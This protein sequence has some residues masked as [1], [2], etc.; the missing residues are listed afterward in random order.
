MTYRLKIN[1]AIEAANKIIK[2]IVG[3]MVKTHKDWHKKLPFALL[4]YRTSVQTLTG[5]MPYSLFY[6]MR[7]SIKVE[8]LSLQVLMETKLE[9][10]K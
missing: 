10:A 4:A 6:N 2:R 7:L 8:I 1:G 9:K 5:A 3:N